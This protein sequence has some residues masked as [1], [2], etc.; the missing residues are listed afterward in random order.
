MDILTTVVYIILF[1]I[2]M[3]F[4][5]SI[6]M[7]KPFMPKK[8]AALVLVCAFIIGCLG[9]AFFLAPLYDEVPEVVS[10]IEKVV[11]S[12]NETMYLDLSSAS[13]ID[14]LKENLTHMDGVYSF[15]VTG[16]TL[17]MW[18]FTDV[19]Y[20]YMNEVLK[21]IDGN[22]KNLTVNQSGRIDIDLMPGYDYNSALKS[23]S[24]W[25]NLV[26]AET[27]SYAQVHVEIGMAS[28]AID[29]VSDYLLE[30]GIVPSKMEGPVQQSI[31]QTNNT[32]LSNG[33]FVLISGGIG[34][35]VA[36]MGIYFDKVVVIFRKLKRSNK[37]GRRKR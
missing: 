37:S 15:N 11:P 23:F 18:Q 19:E 33:E 31:N 36:L 6:G 8:E 1:I 13:D 30:R 21:N 2:I 24:D 26:Y 9:G 28:S 35:V 17:Y 27:L 14:G 12:N 5:F 29:P 3:V 34:V 32:M 25:Y 4:V 16:I 10:T 20:D 22:Y 7:L